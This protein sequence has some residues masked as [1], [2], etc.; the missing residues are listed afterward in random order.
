[1]DLILGVFVSMV[2]FVLDLVF[3][4]LYLFGFAVWFDALQGLDGLVLCELVYLMM[5]NGSVV[6]DLYSAGFCRFI[7]VG[8]WVLV[9]CF[10]YLLIL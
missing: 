8:A 4:E 5:I 10:W 7:L 6:K 1:M 2:T 9:V 3:S